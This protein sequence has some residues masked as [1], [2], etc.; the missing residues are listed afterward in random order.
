LS[1][2]EKPEFRPRTN[3]GAPKRAK[4]S[5][6]A[7][8]D[9]R[10]WLPVPASVAVSPRDQAQPQNAQSADKEEGRNRPRKGQRGQSGLGDAG[11][12]GGPAGYRSALLARFFLQLGELRHMFSDSA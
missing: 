7:H 4:V 11:A 1:E 12:N 2:N 6:A 8:A 5:D 9:E 10:R 3:G